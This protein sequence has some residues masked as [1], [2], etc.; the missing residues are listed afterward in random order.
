LIERLS[1]KLLKFTI[2]E[3]GDLA[4]LKGDPIP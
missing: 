2:N 4:R 1:G 3:S